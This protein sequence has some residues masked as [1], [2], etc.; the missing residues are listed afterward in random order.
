MA[1]EV[2]APMHPQ[3]KSEGDLP[4]LHPSSPRVGP[5]HPLRRA[6]SVVLR[7]DCIS[8]LYGVLED[9]T[10]P[11]LVRDPIATAGGRA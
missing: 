11:D 2:L 1:Q 6:Q 7:E 9:L 10:T 3:D 8:G 4:C 5:V